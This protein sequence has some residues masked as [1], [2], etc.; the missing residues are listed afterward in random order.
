MYRAPFEANIRHRVWESSLLD[1]NGL[2][3]KYVD[4]SIIPAIATFTFFQKSNITDAVQNMSSLHL[5]YL[6]TKLS[7]DFWDLSLLIVWE[8]SDS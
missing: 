2:S 4:L 8:W 3:L 7:F 1:L 6:P 5:T